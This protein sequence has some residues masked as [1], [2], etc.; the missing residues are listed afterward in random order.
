MVIFETAM[1]S[2][3]PAELS[4]FVARAR[5][6]AKVSGE[7]DVLISG[8]SRL[9]ELNRRFRRKNNPTDVLSFPRPDGGDIAISAAIALA[10]ARGYGHAAAVALH[11]LILPVLLHL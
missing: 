6:L 10:N 4:R 8:N 5:A 3:T 2:V 9:K 1:A 11:I 7:V